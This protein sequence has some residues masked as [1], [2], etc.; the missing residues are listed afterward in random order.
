VSS[1]YE[2]NIEPWS[3]E[4][5]QEVQALAEAHFEEV[6]GDVEPNRKFDI[7]KDLMKLIQDAGVLR[8]F[9]ARIKDRL[10]GYYTWNVHLDVE[11]KGLLIALMGAWYVAPGHPRAAFDMFQVSRDHLAQEGVKCLFPHHREQGRGANIGR[12]FERQGAKL[13]QRTYTLWIGEDHAEH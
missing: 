13:T 7:D 10:V 6:D 4:L 9:T 5:W 12:F 2:I 11:S 1:R 8:I 3:D